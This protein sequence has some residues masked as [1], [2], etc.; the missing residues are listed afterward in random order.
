MK[1]ILFITA[2][3]LGFGI[4]LEAQTMVGLSKEKVAEEMKKEH[5][6]FHKDDSVI[7]QRFNYLKFVNNLR[8]QTWIIYFDNEDIA[9]TS[10]LVCDYSDYEDKVLDLQGK[11]RQTGENTWEFLSGSDTILVEVIKQEWYFSI[12]E[13]RKTSA[14]D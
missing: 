12:R 7:R 11:Y 14:E 1:R 9:V 10:K 2:F 5:R 6:D 4:A 8:T 13:T 3:L